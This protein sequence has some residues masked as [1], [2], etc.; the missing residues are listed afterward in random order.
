M[1]FS[2]AHLLAGRWCGF[3]FSSLLHGALLTLFTLSFTQ[4][5]LRLSLDLPRLNLVRVSIGSEAPQNAPAPQ[6]ATE[7]APQPAQAPIQVPAPPQAP[8]V[9]VQVPA[10]APQAAPE[11]APVEAPAQASMPAEP[12]SAP[13]AEP[14]GAEELLRRAFAEARDTAAP[15]PVVSGGRSM[16]DVALAEARSEAQKRGR[17]GLVS[18]ARGD[19]QGY[20]G[21][22]RDSVISRI[23]PHFTTRPRSDGKIFETA[24]R[25]EIA[26]DG[27]VTK[28]SL[29]SSSGDVTFDANVLRAIREAGKMEPPLQP[30]AKS[31]DLFFNSR[32]IHGR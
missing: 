30:E 12:A 6:P 18:G 21:A 3:L 7:P 8:Q 17:G 10:P 11:P 24:V 4:A 19:G 20:H 2:T 27:S 23:Q 1:R 15:A 16:L 28:V 14:P 29:L 9:P 26:D 25:L 32:L 31:L 13:K 5:P 22:Y